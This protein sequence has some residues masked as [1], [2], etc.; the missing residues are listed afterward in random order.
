MKIQK[1]REIVI[2][3]ERVR[4]VR[5]R[6][7]TRF[8]ACRAC[9]SE[10]DFI[11]LGEAATLFD[12][13]AAQL[14]QFIKANSGHYEVDSNGEIHV[15]LVSLLASMKSQTDGSRIKLVKE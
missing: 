8:L 15:C 2:E 5:K 11:S 7:K 4:I 10:V 3:F 13:R 1:Q 9:A 12:T 6:A 14:F